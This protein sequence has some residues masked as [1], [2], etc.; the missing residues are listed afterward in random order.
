MKEV[1]GCLSGRKEST[2]K[3]FAEGLHLAGEKYIVTIDD[4]AK[5]I[6]G[7]KVCLAYRD[8]IRCWTGL[9]VIYAY[10]MQ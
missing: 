1:V 10:T 2:D 5:V 9:E 6:A 7:R 8:V 3:A 4:E